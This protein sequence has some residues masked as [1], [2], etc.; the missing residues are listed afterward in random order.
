MKRTKFYE[1]F[2]PPQF[3]QMPAVGLDISETS[4]RFTELVETR[5]G[6]VIGRF[7]ELAIPRGVIELGEVKKIPELNAIFKT[8]KKEYNIE[9]VTMALP[10]EKAYLFDLHLPAMKHNQ[11]R[12]AIELAFEE[13]VPINVADAV[14]DYDIEMETDTGIDVRVTATNNSIIDGYL[15]ALLDTGIKPIAFEIEVQSIARAVIPEGDMGTSMIMDFGKLRTS[16]AVVSNGGVKFASTI[17]T[18]SLHLTEVIAKDLGISYEEAEKLKISQGIEAGGKNGKLSPSVLGIIKSLRE[19]INKNYLYW[20][21]YNN[22]ADKKHVVVKKIYLSGGGS[23]LQ[24]FTSYL[25][26]GLPVSVELANV[27]VNVNTLDQYVP[28][29]NFNE[30][31]HYST[32]IG[33]ALRRPN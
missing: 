7:A 20:Q 32:A 10:E 17:P 6:F 1:Y 28:E 8:L 3:L 13:H 31:L 30:S 24:G 27:M 23:N 25:G 19:D 15:E 12:G 11:I 29:I 16:I 9:Y 26:A 22:D 18:G 33:L 5:K 4:M 14:F 2:P 21:S